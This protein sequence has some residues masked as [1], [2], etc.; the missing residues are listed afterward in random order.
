MLLQNEYLVSEQLQLVN[1]FTCMDLRVTNRWALNVE[2]NMLQ[3]P[4][5]YIDIAN[6]NV[7]LLFSV[8]YNYFLF[9]TY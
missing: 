4:R 5:N 9:I 2:S 1:S 8:T 6:G 7:I 3:C